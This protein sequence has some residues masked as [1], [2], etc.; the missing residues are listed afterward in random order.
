MI[1]GALLLLAVEYVLGAFVE[2]GL[3]I[4]EH[5][6]GTATLRRHGAL[7]ITLDVILSCLLWPY[8]VLRDVGR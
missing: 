4:G 3:V 7:L 1:A 5:P 8:V 2:L 6:F